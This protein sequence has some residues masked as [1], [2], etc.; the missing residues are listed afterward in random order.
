MQLIESQYPIFFSFKNDMA[1]WQK[2]LQGI[3]KTWGSEESRDPEMTSQ[4]DHLSQSD[5]DEHSNVPGLLKNYQQK[6]NKEITKGRINVF[7]LL[8]TILTGQFMKLGTN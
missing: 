8:P 5:I 2:R 1:E 3:R 4:G 6:K 7:H